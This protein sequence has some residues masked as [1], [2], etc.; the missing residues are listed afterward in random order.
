VRVTARKPH[1]QIMVVS[2]GP[3]FE[4]DTLQCCHCGGHFVVNKGSGK[5]RGYCMKCNDVTCGGANCW[6][7]RPY[8]KLVDEGRR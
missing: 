8:Q 7:C 3:L 5:R 6:Q 2:D 4:A 1:G